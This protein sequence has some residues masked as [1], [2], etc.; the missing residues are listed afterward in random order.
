MLAIAT[1]TL[2]DYLLFAILILFVF[3]DFV[4]CG[5]Q[6]AFFALSQSDIEELSNSESPRD[7]TIV[8]LMRNSDR[9]FASIN[10]LDIF[11]KVFI[12]T[13]SFIL[14][15]HLLSPEWLNKPI[16]IVVLSILIVILIDITPKLYAASNP[17]KFSYRSANFINIIDKINSP[18]SSLLVNISNRGDRALHHQRHELS[19]DELSR[20]LQMTSK[21][22][23]YEDEKDMLEEIIRFKDTIVDDIKV[24]R[25]DM[26]AV[27]ITLPFDKVVDFIVDAGFSRIPVYEKDPDNIKG[28]LYVKDLL[29]Y[30][31]RKENFKWQSLIRPAYFVPGTK[32]IE[33][34][35]EEF[36]T[37]KNHM[38]IVVD[39]Y[40]A[41]TG[42]VT[43]E[44]ILEEIVGDISDEYDV[45]TSFYTITP[46]GTYI[47]DGKTPLEDFFR[48]TGLSEEEFEQ[49]TNESDT[50]AGFILEL[51]GNFPKRKEIINF[52]DYQF[53]VEELTK[54]KI[55]KIRFIPPKVQKS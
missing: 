50:L 54:R 45:E 17:K 23:E 41:T 48:V 7:K 29:P 11:S 38:A 22:K 26:I 5:A 19:M 32:H 20:A 44:D 6:I 53:Q 21:D 49:Y 13:L 39:E 46:D 10:I 18:L 40:G 47:F 33:D 14:F 2:S 1:P 15:Q 30:L 8:H 43:M 51:H 12:F 16:W 3:F 35:L 25:S 52:N 9:L 37:N 27:D 31:N 28:I 42:I 36:R 4:A 24:S 55:V 34:L